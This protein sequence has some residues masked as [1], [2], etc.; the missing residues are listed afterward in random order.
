[1]SYFQQVIQHNMAPIKTKFYY[2]WIIVALSAMGVFFSG[3]GQ[4]YTISLFIDEYIKEFGWSRSTVSS[5]YSAATLLAGILLFLVGRLIDKYGQRKMVV[6]IGSMLALACFWNSFVSNMVM[7]FIGFFLI[8]LF[9]QGSMTLLPNTLVPQWFIKYRGRAFSFMAIGGFVSSAAFPIINAWLITTYDWQTTWTVWGILLLVIFVPVAYVFTR[10][11]P[12]DIGLLPD[13]ATVLKRTGQEIQEDETILEENWTLK[14][15]RKTVAFWLLLFIVAIPALVNTGLTFHLVSILGEGGMKPGVAALILSLMAIIGFPITFISG[16][17]LER[18]KVNILLAIVF[19]GEIFMI[20]I[21]F[22]T[23][24]IFMAI[25]FGVV[26]GITG[27][28][29][30]ITLAIV[31]PSYFGRKHI[32]SIKG[33]A[34]TMMV[35]GSAFGP[36]PF[37]VAFDM[38]KGYEEILLATLI[39]PVAAAIAAISAKQP[40]KSETLKS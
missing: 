36:L 35:I 4:T 16:F 7:L 10:N 24:S 40:V 2:G 14:E 1:M 38:F 23:D 30:R 8:R 37:G 13:D 19:I 26:W 34:M 3:P 9:G 6:I 11:K 15:A 12:E 22:F 25:L 5:I 39:L 33:V 28:L 18:V 21:I 29:E 20:I 17:I 32:G 31:W 27:G